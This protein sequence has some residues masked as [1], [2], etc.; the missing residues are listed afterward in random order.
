MVTALKYLADDFLNIGI[1][2]GT[3]RLIKLEKNSSRL[4]CHDFYEIILV[5][6][7]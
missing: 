6:S 5:A 1:V 7:L 3:Y 4:H 2:D